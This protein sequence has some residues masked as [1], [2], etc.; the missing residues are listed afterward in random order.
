MR[1]TPRERQGERVS[2]ALEL[3]RAAA[4]KVAGKGPNVLNSLDAKL[5]SA[6]ARPPSPPAEKAPQPVE[7]RAFLERPMGP[8]KGSA[9][10]KPGGVS[11]GASP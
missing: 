10:E 4:R 2:A 9:E 1:P 5:K 8:D 11:S 7:R 3:C 6:P